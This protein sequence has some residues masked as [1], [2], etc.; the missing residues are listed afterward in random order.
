M[1]AS[2]AYDRRLPVNLPSLLLIDD[3]VT[4][5]SGRSHSPVTRNHIPIALSFGKN[6]SKRQNTL[7]EG[8]ILV[9]VSFDYFFASK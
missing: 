4:P 1:H 6:L 3:W 8:I 2:H 7:F 5:G 9:D